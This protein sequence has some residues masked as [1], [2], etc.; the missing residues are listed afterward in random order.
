MGNF[1]SSITRVQPILKALYEIDPSG[2]SWIKSLLEITTRNASP[3]SAAKEISFGH[4]LKPPQFEFPVDPSKAYL[5]WLIAH[6]EKLSSP[7]ATAWRTWDEKTQ[8]MRSRFLLGDK[9]VQ[10][11]AISNIEKCRSLPKTTWWRLEGV[12]YVDCALLTDSTAIFV[13]GK[14]TEIGPSREVLWY[15]QRNQIYRILDC[16]AAY[17]RKERLQHYFVVAIVDKALM[18][19]DLVRRKEFNAVMSPDVICNSLPHLNNDELKKIT[20]HYT[21]VTTWE[22]I[23]ERFDL[24]S[25]IR[26][27]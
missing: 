5:K 8:K 17:A 27:H 12:N 18:D 6:P 13:E 16:A 24:G 19:R 20:R 26:L 21:G 23:I 7:P 11:I 15:Q 2:E 1:N 22:D 25:K 3:T 4:L 10:T 9:E 14:R